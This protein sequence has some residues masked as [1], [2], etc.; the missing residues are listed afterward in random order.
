MSE[1]DELYNSV[2]ALEND[3]NYDDALF[4]LYET[5]LNKII[6]KDYSFCD[7]Y[8]NKTL[9]NP[10]RV[11]VLVHMLNPL[12]VIKDKLENWRKTKISIREP[13]P[14][15]LWQ[16]AVELS[17]KHSVSSVAKALRLSYTDLRERV[18]GPSISKRLSNFTRSLSENNK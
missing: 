3:G 15:K 18:Y 17:K 10:L 4:K 7:L 8:I 14:Q 6:N 2:I 16:Q 9:D 13:I 5:L 1:V 11:D 12:S